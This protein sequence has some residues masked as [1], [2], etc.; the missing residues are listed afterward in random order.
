MVRDDLI[1]AAYDA[2]DP[3]VRSELGMELRAVRQR[4][5]EL[6]QAD[7]DP[8]SPVA[9]ELTAHSYEVVT[10]EHPTV[11]PGRYA[12][13]LAP[14][15]GPLGARPHVSQP[16][17]MTA[18]GPRP[19]NARGGFGRSSLQVLL[20][21]GL[22]AVI[23][24]AAIS[25][26]D[27]FDGS[28][29]TIGSGDG[30]GNELAAVDE[31]DGVLTDIR[32]VL[33]G[34][35]LTSVMVEQRD[36]TILLGGSVPTERDRNAAMGAAT[37]LVGDQPLDAS[38]LVVQSVAPLATVADGLSRP[39][40]LQGEL[41]RVLAATPIIFD[42][43]QT[44]LTELHLRILNNVA[45]VLSAY[46]DTSVTIVG[47]TDDVGNDAENERLSLS[48][49]E[50][51]KD[52]LVSQ[53]IGAQALG[54]QARGEQTSTG[55]QALASLERRVEFE[56]AGGVPGIQTGTTLRVG[57]VAPSARNDLA[58]TQSIVDA[59]NVLAAE[60]N[61]EVAV[62]DN[63]FVPEEA[64]AAV[65]SYA[66]AGFDL[67]IA[68][69]SQ[70]GAALVDIAPQF[71]ETVFAWGT[72][73]DTFGLPNVYAYDAAAQEGGYVLGAVAS[74]LSSGNVIGVV[75]PIEVGDA[76]LY[77]NGFRAGAQAEQPAA[78]VLVSYTGSFSDIGLASETAQAHL[79][80][81]ADVLTGSAQMVVGAIATASENGA[82]WFGTQANQTS[83]APDIVVASQVYR[84]EVVLRQIISDIDAGTPSGTTY[85]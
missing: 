44:A 51:V 53:G 55:S 60:R 76:E 40:A 35:G 63:T 71:P 15:S 46:P 10:D 68:H 74:L 3:Q 42:S 22:V 57:I 2:V 61:V 52:Y 37:A 27:R 6:I 80:A 59:V 26:A 13:P 41:D 73:S 7:R 25:I 12:P 16:A 14:R 4:I 39:D 67:V 84:W 34:L 11:E 47:F 64:A 33:D 9:P 58:F 19:A 72:A 83:L 45:M 29:R 70:F 78:N 20:A 21:V 38:A 24:A 85:S 66:E 17:A 28:S 1:E 56:V 50:N 49:A 77:V 79:D 31:G 75:G 82:L 43:G 30:D 65:Q 5:G 32:A 18:R 48:R 54:I 36:D 69:G 23:V 62:T 81:G 8:E